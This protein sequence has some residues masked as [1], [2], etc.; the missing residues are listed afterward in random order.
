MDS[1]QASTQSPLAKGEDSSMRLS[2]GISLKNVLLKSIFL[3]ILLNLLFALFK[4]VPWLARISAYNSLFPGRQRLPFGEIQDKAYNLS[5]YQ[6]DAM[7]RSHAIAAGKSPNEYRVIVIG[8]SSVWGYLLKPDQTLTASLNRMHLTTPDG[9]P[10]RFY[11][12]GYPTI[13]L[14]KDILI[15]SNAM[16]YQPDLV[17][18]LTTLE[19]FPHSKQLTSPIVQ[20]NPN[21]VRSLIRAYNLDLDPLDSNLVDP[22]FLEQTIIGQRRSLADF[23]RLQLYGVLWA[24]TG[25]DQFYPETYD[26]PQANLEASESFY[27]LN[28]PTLDA[29]K[30]ALDSL[31]AG[32]QISGRVP[33]L[34]VNEPIYISQGEN[35]DIRYNFF[36]PRWAYDQYRSLL[37][38]FSQSKGWAYLDLWDLI[39]PGE[40][41]NSAIH[42]TPLGTER[43]AS[44]IIPAVKTLVD[45]TYVP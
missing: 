40:F 36:Y 1:N 33:I 15:L 17:V 8:D 25:I 19:A 23:L 21:S 28:P 30:L 26:P 41:T 13:N 12:L 11:N 22:T 3:F 4:P 5:L 27:D 10:V 35:S 2:P 34:L 45:Q 44:Q 29:Q 39:P 16:K 24:A 18:W 31:S 6:L 9:K 7:F 14:T 43:L 37:M 42:L 38:Q 20:H 32:G